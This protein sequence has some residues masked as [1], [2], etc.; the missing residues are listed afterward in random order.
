MRCHDRQGHDGLARPAGEVV[1]VE[2]EPGWKQVEF[3]RD[4]RGVVPGPEAEQGQPDVGEDPG[5]L[6]AAQVADQ[7]GGS[8]HVLGFDGVAR[9][10]QGDVR[11][12]G[13]REVG[14]ALVERGP[15]AVLALVRTDPGGRAGGLVV[16]A[17]ADELPEEQVLGIHG[18]VGLEF[19][20]PP[21]GRV[22]KRQERVAA[23]GG[24]LLGRVGG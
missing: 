23:A 20:L 11:L 7:L 13:R 1:R 21:A 24:G 9:Q 2:R 22:L 10:A 19:A 17:D 4:R 5:L 8:E 12:H 6:D 14:G 18:D 16:A 3:G 15:A